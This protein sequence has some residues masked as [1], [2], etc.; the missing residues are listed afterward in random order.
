MQKY[1]DRYLTKEALPQMAKNL[2]LDIIGCIIFSIGIYVF[3]N[4]AKIAPGGI[5]GMSIVIHYIW[6]FLP[7]G[8]LNF[9]INVPLLILSWLFLGKMLTVKTLRS[10][11]MVTVIIDIFLPHLLPVYTGNRLLGSL[12]GGILVGVG[13]GIIFTSG[14]TTGGTDIMS[15]LIKLKRPHVSIGRAFLIIDTLILLSSIYV[16]RDLESGMFGM[17][18]LFCTSRVVDS[19]LYGTDK[20]AIVYVISK[21]TRQIAD[22]ILTDLDR[23]V[24]F[25]NGR[26]AFSGEE[27]NII[28]C[29]VRRNEFPKLKNIALHVDRNAFIIIGEFDEIIG[30][31]FK[32]R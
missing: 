9:M 1:I 23:G 8:S 3:V 26:G 17:I 28:L 2:A 12:F 10:I 18:S 25:L 6:P 27:Q 4:P 5:S 13:I 20:G 22:V 32:R 30:E 21:H 24:T 31:G 11:L 15:Y 16:F 14:S 7:L 19:I 29:A